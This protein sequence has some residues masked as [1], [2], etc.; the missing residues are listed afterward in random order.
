MLIGETNFLDK[1]I[2][3][4]AHHQLPTKHG[5]TLVE[6]AITIVIIGLLI[7]GILVGQSL[8]ES[9]KISRL[10]SDINQ[11]DIATTQFYTKFKQIPGDSTYFSPSGNN[12][13]S[14]DGGYCPAFA[15]PGEGLLF[16]AHLS[17]AKMISKTYAASCLTGGASP[18]MKSGAITP[19]YQ[20]KAFGKQ[21]IFQN[22]VQY[23]NKTLGFR[24]NLDPN[25]ILAIKSKVGIS[26]ISR[27]TDE[28]DFDN[29]GYPISTQKNGFADY[30]GWFNASTDTGLCSYTYEYYA[31]DCGEGSDPCSTPTQQ[32]DIASCGD[33]RAEYGTLIYYL[34]TSQ[35]R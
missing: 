31:N 10:M 34:N 4:T 30:L 23:E 33:S 9:A 28:N 25:F 19:I 11:Y 18:Q 14:I 8:V 15:Y 13:G 35:I 32:T 17:Q 6:L 16:F 3:P 7:G 24:L 12:N 21:G 27:N 2:Y 29:Y 1:M 20:T 26:A 5:F 22:T